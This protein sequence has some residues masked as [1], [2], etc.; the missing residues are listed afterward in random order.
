MPPKPKVVSASL[1]VLLMWGNQANAEN[2]IKIIPFSEMDRSKP[3]P[4]S[5]PSTWFTYEDAR[6]LPPLSGGAKMSYVL[7]VDETGAVVKCAVEESSGSP[8]HDQAICGTIMM[9][10]RFVPAL[11]KNKVATKEQ[12]AGR[13]FWQ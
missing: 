10:A 1:F 4:R 11:D 8:M 5:S 13:V 6:G 3:I 7:T 12:Y 2:R 9:R